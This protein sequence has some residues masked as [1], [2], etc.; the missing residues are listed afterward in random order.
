MLFNDTKGGRNVE[1]FMKVYEECLREA[2]TSHPE[3]YRYGLDA[4]P[5]VLEKM[6]PAIY[7]GSYNKD[8]RAFRATCKKL[9]IKHTYSAI[10]HYITNHV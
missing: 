4:I 3:E 2:I 10:A 9:G 6:R 8:S 1:T 7:N 5:G